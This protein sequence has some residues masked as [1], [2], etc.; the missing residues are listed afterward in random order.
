M[1]VSSWKSRL[2]KNGLWWV[3]NSAVAVLVAIAASLPQ[4]PQNL[5]CS[6]AGISRDYF[7]GERD[8][9]YRRAASYFRPKRIA[10]F[11]TA[12][13]CC[14]AGFRAR[15]LPRWV[16]F[17]L[18]RFSVKGWNERKRRRQAFCPTI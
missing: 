3:V 16:L 8:R 15:L 1:G 10:H 6:G 11:T 7:V 13:D 14:A 2:L 4:F 18:K 17:S 9:R 5:P 12:G